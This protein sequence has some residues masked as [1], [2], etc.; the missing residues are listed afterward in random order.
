MS[1]PLYKSRVWKAGASWHARR[2]SLDVDG[3]LIVERFE[4]RSFAAALE[5]AVACWPKPVGAY[6]VAFGDAL[7]DGFACIRRA[8]YLLPQVLVGAA[9]ARQDDFVLVGYGDGVR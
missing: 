2:P 6:S 8:G 4:A 1:T 7:I 5:W 3:P 9:A